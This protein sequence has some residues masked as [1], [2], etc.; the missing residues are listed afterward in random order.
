MRHFFFFMHLLH[1]SFFC[2]L[3][4]FAAPRVH[5]EKNG[6]TS[7][8]EVAVILRLEIFCWG[9]S[10]AFAISRPDIPLVWAMR[11]NK[12]QI[13]NTKTFRC[14]F[15]MSFFF[16]SESRS[17]KLQK[18]IIVGLFAGDSYRWDEHRPTIYDPNRPSQFGSILVLVL[19]CST[20]EAFLA[21]RMNKYAHGLRKK[22]Y[23]LC[24]IHPER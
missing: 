23:R 3:L 22:K 17:C 6:K 7:T 18:K 13:R 9:M 11:R 12:N 5:E 15:F 4:L 21:S 8:K 19:F 24:N 14:V 1:C 20:N 16:F 2:A 10:M